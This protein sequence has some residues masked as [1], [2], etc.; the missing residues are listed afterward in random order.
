MITTI[1]AYAG[2][3]CLRAASY[4]A[5]AGRSL[6][7]ISNVTVES[8]PAGA[9]VVTLSVEVPRVV[10]GLR[11]EL[12]DSMEIVRVEAVRGRQARIDRPLVHGYPRGSAA[13]LLM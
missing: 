11:L 7:R 8:A 9:R 10:Q 12:D 6:H 3:A 1:R 5:R 2:E 13:K 4:L